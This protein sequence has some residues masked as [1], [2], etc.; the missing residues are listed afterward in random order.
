MGESHT[1]NWILEI[2]ESQLPYFDKIEGT[3]NRR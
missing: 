2:N 1:G 3:G